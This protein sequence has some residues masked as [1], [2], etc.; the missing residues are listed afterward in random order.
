MFE[1]A[2]ERTNERT[3]YPS[4]ESIDFANG[5][6]IRNLTG[7]CADFPAGHIAEEIPTWSLASLLGSKAE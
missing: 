5:A 4:I 6:R 7:P 3:N 2:N 1:R